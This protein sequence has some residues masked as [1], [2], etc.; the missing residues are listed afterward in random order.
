M[1]F[2]ERR[3]ASRRVAVFFVRPVVKAPE[4]HVA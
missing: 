1:G 3:G 4:K 2:F